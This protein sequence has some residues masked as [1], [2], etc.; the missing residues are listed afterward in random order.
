MLEYLYFQLEA[1]LDE[2]LDPEPRCVWVE[3][4]KANA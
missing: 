4:L 1:L 2:V 3:G